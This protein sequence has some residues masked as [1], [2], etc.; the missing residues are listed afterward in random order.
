[1]TY[2]HMADARSAGSEVQLICP[3]SHLHSALL[4]RCGIA[5]GQA[6]SKKRERQVGEAQGAIVVAQAQVSS[7]E[8]QLQ[9]LTAVHKQASVQHT[10]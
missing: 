6:I 4:L 2:H 9:E 3:L 1:M 8:M 10:P 5:D 7:L